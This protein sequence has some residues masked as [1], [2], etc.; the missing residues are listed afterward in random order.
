MSASN[1]G[2][3]MISRRSHTLTVSANDNPHG[4]VE[5]TRPKYRLMEPEKDNHTQ[6]ISVSRRLAVN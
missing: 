3:I 1:G 6:Y 4:T 2:R 5:F